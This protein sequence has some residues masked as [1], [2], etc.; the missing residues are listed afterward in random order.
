LRDV[1]AKTAL[2]TEVNRTNPTLV[3]SA[4]PGDKLM[5]MA[6]SISNKVV[7]IRTIAEIQIQQTQKPFGATLKVELQTT[8]MN[9]ATQ[10]VLNQWNFHN[11]KTYHERAKAEATEVL[12]LQL[13]KELDAW[14][15]PIK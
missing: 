13:K 6:E 2:D 3:K 10:L 9:T 8:I 4:S 12:K 7:W 5:D 1:L 14:T 11:K 15:G